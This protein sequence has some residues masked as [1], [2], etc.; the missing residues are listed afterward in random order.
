MTGLRRG[1][2]LRDCYA[3]GRSVP[4]PENE[5]LLASLLKLLGHTEAAPHRI[6]GP[7]GHGGNDECHRLGRLRFGV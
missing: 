4:A 6:V 1:N 5:A 7:G 3:A 2:V